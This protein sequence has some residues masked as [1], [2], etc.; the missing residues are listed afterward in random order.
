MAID[1]SVSDA[2]VALHIWII[3]LHS[4]LNVGCIVDMLGTSVPG[5]NMHS[6]FMCLICVHLAPQVYLM[7]PDIHIN[8]TRYNGD[9]NLK[10]FLPWEVDLDA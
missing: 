10:P 3:I 6:M 2:M 4:P 5:I 8:R 9:S 7:Q 1:I